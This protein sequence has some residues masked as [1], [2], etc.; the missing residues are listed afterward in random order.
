M[1]DNPT[2]SDVI[3]D[4]SDFFEEK[5]ETIKSS[6]VNDIILDP[7]FGFGKTI[8]HNYEILDR[9]SEF[10]RFK[11]PLLAGMSRKSMIWKLL[12][13]KPADTLSETVALHLLALQNGADILRVHDVKEH[14]NIV[15]I[16]NTLN[17]KK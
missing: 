4:I 11:L 5:L 2:Y 14:V 10:K 16:Y 7:G 6:W 12:D 3:D 1:Q 9:F 8:E 17:E 13:S 15:K